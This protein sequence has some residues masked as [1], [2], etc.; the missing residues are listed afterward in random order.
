MS[1]ESH[2]QRRVTRYT[3]VIVGIIDVAIVASDNSTIA[4]GWS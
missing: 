3:I 2:C 4:G 1:G